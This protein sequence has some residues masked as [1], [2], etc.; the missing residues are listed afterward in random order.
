MTT[1]RRVSREPYRLKRDRRELVVAVAIAAL[2]VLATAV[3][4]WI[5]APND[6][7][8]PVLTTPNITLP[9]DTTPTAPVSTE[10]PVTT[11][12]PGG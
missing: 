1:G 10:P 8:S 5:L 6:D 12:A 4:V 11:V 9:T 2:I 7:S 3:A